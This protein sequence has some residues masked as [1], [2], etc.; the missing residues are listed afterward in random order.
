[1]ASQA[2]AQTAS[3]GAGWGAEGRIGGPTSVYLGRWFSDD[4]SLLVGGSVSASSSKRDASA[5]KNENKS[6]DLSA[7]LRRSWGAGS[8]RPFLAVGPTLNFSTSKNTNSFNSTSL[9]DK[10]TSHGMGARGDFGATVPISSSAYLGLSSG[11]F[12]GHNTSESTP[13][14]GPKSKYTSNGFSAGNLQFMIGFRF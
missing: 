3:K 14:A 9:A 10:N 13:A 5:D 6:A 12:F 1:M 8:V 4:W 11:V 7:L 2:G